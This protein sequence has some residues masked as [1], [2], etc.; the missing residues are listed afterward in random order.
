[1]G[2]K[3]AAAIVMALV[4]WGL[5][6]PLAPYLSPRAPLLAQLVALGA[7]CAFGLALYFALIHVSGAQ[8]MG[9]LLKRLRRGG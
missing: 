9:M 5:A 4:L 2:R 7:L 3:V 8:P 6:I 1:M